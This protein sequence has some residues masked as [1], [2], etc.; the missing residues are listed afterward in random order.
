MKSEAAKSVN[1]LAAAIVNELLQGPDPKSGI[2]RV[3]TKEVK[4]IGD[5]KLDISG[6][7]AT[8]NLSKDF[9]ESVAGGKEM[10]ELAIMSIVNSLTELKEIQTVQILLEGRDDG[11]MKSGTKLSEPRVRDTAVI[12]IDEKADVKDEQKVLP[13]ATGAIT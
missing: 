13:S 4:L 1:N 7:K 11:V 10:E 2:G 12:S 9:S 8:V 6:A 3:I 5:V